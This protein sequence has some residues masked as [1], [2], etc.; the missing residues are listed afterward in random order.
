[1][2]SSLFRREPVTADAEDDEEVVAPYDALREYLGSLLAELGTEDD[3]AADREPI[4]AAGMK[5]GRLIQ[6]VDRSERR[7]MQRARSQNHPCVRQ[8]SDV[9]DLPPVVDT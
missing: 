5:L 6:W 1:V 7:A 9:V 8:R 2:T 4:D 3:S